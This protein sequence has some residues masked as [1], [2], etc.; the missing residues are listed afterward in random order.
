MESRHVKDVMERRAR[1]MSPPQGPAGY[2]SYPD[3]NREPYGLPSGSPDMGRGP[4]DYNRGP[5]ADCARGQRGFD[6][7][8][9]ADPPDVDPRDFDLRPHPADLNQGSHQHLDE[10]SRFGDVPYKN[11]PADVRK[12][13][14]RKL[15][16]KSPERQKQQRPKRKDPEDDR[17][18]FMY[19]QGFSI[20]PGKFSSSSPPPSYRA[21][22]EH[23]AM[24][25]PT[26][27]PL[28]G[29]DP[30]FPMPGP[31]E[32]D[33]PSNPLGNYRSY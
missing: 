8:P 29:L 33:R 24:R 3:H 11:V 2:R 27:E 9:P 25:Y 4:R 21:S 5:P 13:Y 1:E 18:Y 15:R 16:E 32:N 19:P 30:A 17:T 26:D 10:N 28:P 14:E 22:A 6:R 7:S 20:K 12:A 23:P 31:W